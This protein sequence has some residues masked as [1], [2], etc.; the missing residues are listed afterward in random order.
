[1]AVSNNIK[2][3]KLFLSV[4]I[5]G[6]LLLSSCGRIDYPEPEDNAIAFKMGSFEDTEHDNALFGT[7]EYNNRIYIGYSTV[8]NS[9]KRIKPDKCIGYIIQDE[10]STDVRVYT[11]S[12]DAEHN[13]LMEYDNTVKLM[14]QPFFYRAIDPKGQNIE[15][16]E[17]M[18]DLGYE[19]WE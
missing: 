12:D 3:R 17:S 10:D 1:M 6:I 2:M 15:I 11:L 8:N 5:I 14:N 13:F 19:F 18:D 4:L 16:P 9:Y 7:I